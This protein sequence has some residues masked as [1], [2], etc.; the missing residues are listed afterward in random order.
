MGATES[1]VADAGDVAE[2]GT[3]DANSAEAIRRE[4]G[5]QVF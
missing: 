2:V 5:C 3:A 4:D 1:T